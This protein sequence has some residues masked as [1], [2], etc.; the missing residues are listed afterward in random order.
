MV[1]IQLNLLFFGGLALAYLAV[2]LLIAT[3]TRS[4]LQFAYPL[5]ALVY[6]WLGWILVTQGWRFNPSMQI[7]Q[8][9]FVAVQFY[10]VE[11]AMADRS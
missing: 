6:L 2:R 1:N 5:I 8:L 9:L 3:F 10:W 7:S 11:K 4:P